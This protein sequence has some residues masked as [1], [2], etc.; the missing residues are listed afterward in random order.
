[1]E[2]DFGESLGGSQAT[3]SFWKVPGLPRKFPE[4]PRKFSCD[5]PES[6]LAVESNS[7]PEVPQKFPR[8]PRRSATAPFTGKPDTLSRLT[9]LSLNTLSRPAIA[10]RFPCMAPRVPYHAIRPKKGP[11][12]GNPNVKGVSGREAHNCHRIMPHVSGSLAIAFNLP[13][14]Y[15]MFCY[16][17]PLQV[18]LKAQFS[19]VA[20]CW[21]APSKHFLLCRPL[22]CLG[23][24]AELDS[25]PLLCLMSNR[26]ISRAPTAVLRRQ[27]GGG[28]GGSLDHLAKP[29]PPTFLGTCYVYWRLRPTAWACGGMRCAAMVAHCKR[30][31]HQPLKHHALIM[32]TSKA[33]YLS[34][35]TFL[36]QALCLP[37]FL[38][39]PPPRALVLFKGS[40]P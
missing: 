8:F 38:A 11:T 22:L 21:L 10:L 36:G 18:L 14:F 29:P 40:V 37:T 32:T 7:N 30:E 13:G 34:K 16:G 28:M 20:Q 39:P 6:S 4:L 24:K 12:T 2:T 25:S 31:W 33:L 1:M 17:M 26:Q 35:P 15:A 23:S 3:P 19:Q 9:K 27:L 5:L